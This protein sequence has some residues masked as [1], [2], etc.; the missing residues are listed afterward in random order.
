MLLVEQ[1][2]KR[3]GSLGKRSR[4]P[5]LWT[6][7]Y[8][9]TT[10][11]LRTAS[12]RQDGSVLFVFFVN[13]CVWSCRLLCCRWERGIHDVHQTKTTPKGECLCFSQE[14]EEIHS[15]FFFGFNICLV[16]FCLSRIVWIGVSLESAYAKRC[17]I[18]TWAH[19][20]TH[21]HPSKHRRTSPVAFVLLRF[22]FCFEYSFCFLFVVNVLFVCLIRCDSFLGWTGEPANGWARQPCRARGAIRDAR[23][24]GLPLH[25]ARLCRGDER[26][27]ECAALS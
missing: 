3:T 16:F 13:A 14:K 6:R 8:T 15:S 20:H 24:R 22:I 4:T 9:C 12:T 23:Y 26:G 17:R 27:M 5:R 21:T 18:Y 1:T 19:T 7:G 10:T 25:N 11:F 2:N